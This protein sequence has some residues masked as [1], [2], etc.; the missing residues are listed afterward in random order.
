MNRDRRT[1]R[2]LAAAVACVAAAMLLFE[3][4]VTRLFSMLFF[5][6][7]SFFAISLVMSGLVIGGI[8][9]SHWNASALSE[10]SFATR[11]AMLS[12]VF[13]VG[14]GAG[15][16]ELIRTAHLD[17]GETPSLTGVALYALLFL[18]G[19]V[20]AGAFLA[21]A[22]ARDHTW[23]GTLYA[24]DL[25][26]AATACFA[27]IGAL[28]VLE[29]PAVVVLAAGLGAAA[30]TFIA[31]T[32]VARWV[33][34]GLVATALVSL[35]INASKGG[36]LLRL[37]MAGGVR[38]LAQ[39]EN[40][41]SLVRVFGDD[42]QRMFVIDRSAATFMRHLTPPLEPDSSWAGG[43]QYKAYLT[44]RPLQNVAIIGVG[45]GGDLLPAIYYGAKH[46][47]GYEIN[48]TMI[49]FLQRD[50]RDY[51]AITERP[52]VRLFHNEARVGIKHSGRQYDLIQASLIDTWAATASG[53]FVL[54]EN[55][56]YT[57]EGWRVFLEHLTPSGM[58]TMTRWHLSDAP[59]ETYRLVSLA[60][61]S[62]EDVGIPDA[63][64]HIVLLRS[65]RRDDPIAF[66]T[67]E[68]RSICTIL[69]SKPPFSPEEV[70][71][72]DA[73]AVAS[74]GELMVAPGTPTRDPVLAKLL[75]SKTR[76]A[77][78][79]ESPFNIAPPTDLQPYFFLQV[80][81][82]DL[83]NLT[84]QSF[85]AVTQITFNGVRV[86]IVVAACSLALVVL[87]A[88]LT[89]CTL[90]GRAASAIARKAYR[91]MT[92]YFLG[93]GFG[94]IFVQIGLLQRLII[95]LGRPAFALSVVLFSMLLGT[96]LGAGFS[97][98]LFSGR[99]LRHGALFTVTALILMRLSFYAI[100]SLDGMDSPLG[101]ILI[102]GSV[103]AAVGFVLGCAFPLGVRQVG[104]T[105]EW[106][107][108][109]MWAINGAA[110]IAASVLAAVIGLAWGSGAVVGAGILSYALA[111]AAA[112]LA[113]QSATVT[114]SADQNLAVLEVDQ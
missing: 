32:R 27:A 104:G 38:P 57:R 68:I 111:L 41:Y 69:V 28:R 106:A 36:Q 3:V 108:Q 2:N 63:T 60:A 20:G 93:I 113:R 7:F 92:L 95:V 79:A 33:G 11:L 105:G 46:V 23:I 24:T 97:D 13:S 99:D 51:N 43:A 88:I 112:F 91:W 72:L 10:H 80:R 61:A 98:R 14:I 5:Y 31:P 89:I 35:A 76:L 9:V 16:I 85:G 96:G 71:R 103:V 83:V 65:D 21:L 77:A 81:L 84:R 55:A 67:G 4:V 75:S 73:D 66:G 45:G 1:P 34:L 107:I 70:R 58:L 87:V 40:E 52:E 82:S 30:M 53:G 102:I 101:R 37:N 62:L 42:K 109:K 100:P 78:V 15:V 48:Q 18:P 22:F 29:G 39:R 54:S 17:F 49:D 114:H 86:M 94:Y 56:L 90:P 25:V 59:A 6:H 8:I 74:G 26:A 44:G 64:S 110:S 19:L 50:F 47:D 12:A